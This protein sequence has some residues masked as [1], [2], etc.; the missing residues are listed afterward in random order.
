MPREHVHQLLGEPIKVFN[1]L[2]GIIDDYEKTTEVYSYMHV[3]Y[4][5][6]G[7]CEAFEIFPPGI[8]NFQG[9]TFLEKKV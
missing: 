9:H 3:L 7:C 2:Q 8:P 1:K 5:G 6:A 4:D